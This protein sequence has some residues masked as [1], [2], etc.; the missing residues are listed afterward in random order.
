M[1]G[2]AASTL[3]SALV[4]HSILRRPARE[5]HFSGLTRQVGQHMFLGGVMF[6]IL[7]G[8]SCPP[9]FVPFFQPRCRADI[10]I[11]SG[12][13]WTDLLCGCAWTDVSCGCAC[14]LFKSNGR[15]RK[16][17]EKCKNGDRVGC[18]I[19]FDQVLEGGVPCQMVPVFFTRNGKEVSLCV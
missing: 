6:S 1:D 14:R 13:A 16:F 8:G 5:S 2:R 17:G 15:G 18:G 11:L 10:A 12:C 19:K 4:R 7:H 3:I 9:N